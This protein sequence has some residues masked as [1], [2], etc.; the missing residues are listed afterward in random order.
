M[1]SS[2]Q[3]IQKNIERAASDP[4]TCKNAAKADVRLHD[5]KQIA[6][7]VTPGQKASAGNRS[8]KNKKI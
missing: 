7:P 8:K 6:D 2:S 3:S 1:L 5:K 4:L